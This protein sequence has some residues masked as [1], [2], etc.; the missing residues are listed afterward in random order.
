[1]QFYSC[2]IVY[3][4]NPIAYGKSYDLCFVL[5]TFLRQVAF[6]DVCFFFLPFLCNLVIWDLSVEFMNLGKLNCFL[7][8]AL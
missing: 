3:E 4:I 1:M 2:I 7:V 6:L 8:E 5:A